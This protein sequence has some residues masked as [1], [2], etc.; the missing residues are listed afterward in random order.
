MNIAMDASAR[1]RRRA[2][3]L[4]KLETQDRHSDH[5]SVIQTKSMKSQTP[6]LFSESDALLQEV[7][8]NIDKRPCATVFADFAY[9]DFG[10]L[11]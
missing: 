6:S 11:A 3:P 8:I 9:K 7:M 5:P 4:T 2:L 10:L 1:L